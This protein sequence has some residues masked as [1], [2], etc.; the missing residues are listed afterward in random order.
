MA[1]GQRILCS[2]AKIGVKLP[3]LIDTTSAHT[4]VAMLTARTGP[5]WK[6]FRD[7]NAWEATYGA[8]RK[9]KTMPLGVNLMRSQVK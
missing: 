3:D 1:P 6:L 9:E 2:D 4:I 7:I 8:K 5:H